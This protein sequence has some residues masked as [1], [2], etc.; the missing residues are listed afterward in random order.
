VLPQACCPP[1]PPDRLGSLSR[2]TGRASWRRMETARPAQPQTSA[3]THHSFAAG[4]CRQALVRPILPTACVSAFCITD[5]CCTR[6]ARRESLRAPGIRRQTSALPCG[7]VCSA[8][9]GCDGREKELS[10]PNCSRE[11]G[12]FSWPVLQCRRPRAAG[13]PPAR[14][15]SIPVRPFARWMFHRVDCAELVR[16]LA[17]HWRS[18]RVDRSEE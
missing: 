14:S 10:R 6:A 17:G 1:P 18:I 13:L 15:H 5:R 4:R 2:L 9:T 7:G 11:S 3:R 8:R 12:S 16:A